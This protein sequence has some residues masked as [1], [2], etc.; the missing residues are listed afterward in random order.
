MNTADHWNEVYRSKAA[1]AVSWYRAHLAPSLHYIERA[2]AD[3]HAAIID[4]GSGQATLADDLLAHG[5]RDI[6]LLDVSEAALEA[7]RK[8]LG[9]NA[10]SLHWIVGDVTTVAL[11]AQRYSV[12]HDRAV[13][14]FL[15][16][17][18]QRAAYVAQARRAVRA[19]GHLVI[20]TFALDGP[21]KCSGLD[22]VRYDAASLHAQF[23]AHFD[24]ID[25]TGDMHATPWG[26]AQSFVYA[27]MRRK[28]AA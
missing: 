3:R 25:S 17:A 7:T 24:L 16:G 6:S 13:F 4:V 21:A 22:V 5:Y 19:G 2:A 28:A 10:A 12:W 18:E 14:H 15:T 8:R 23:A 11:E 20:A 26:S 9:D 1:D 27:L